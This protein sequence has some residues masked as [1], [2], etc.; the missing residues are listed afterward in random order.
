MPSRI[1]ENT[2]EALPSSCRNPRPAALASLKNYGRAIRGGLKGLLHWMPNPLGPS[3]GSQQSA[4]HISHKVESPPSKPNIQGSIGYLPAFLTNEQPRPASRSFSQAFSSL[5]RCRAVGGAGT[6]VHESCARNPD[7]S[8]LSIEQLSF[9]IGVTEGP[10]ILMRFH[11]NKPGKAQ[12]ATAS[13]ETQFLKANIMGSK[14]WERLSEGGRRGS[15][16]PVGSTY[17]TPTGPS[18]ISVRGMARNVE[19][20]FRNGPRTYTSDFF[21]VENDGFDVF[22]G[23]DTIRRYLLPA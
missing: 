20:H 1:S 13:F 8:A 14:A 4:E 10:H 12:Q 3:K 23:S 18:S 16:E 22:I 7:R 6:I 17:V 5:R 19:W 11:G 21:V 2:Q 9:G 15:L